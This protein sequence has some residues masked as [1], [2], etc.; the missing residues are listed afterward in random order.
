VAAV[1]R[2][3]LQLVTELVVLPDS[4]LLV[5]EAEILTARRL[6]ASE[7]VRAG[8]VP[9]GA[10][11]DQGMVNSTA[12]P[13]VPYSSHFGAFDGQGVLRATC[14]VIGNAAPVRLPTLALPTFDPTLRDR[15]ERY[16]RGA[17]AE[18]AA[19]ARDRRVGPEFPRSLFRSLWRYALERG[20]STYVLS[21]DALVLRTLRA[22]GHELFRVVGPETPAP[23]RPVFPV[24]V[25]VAEI[26]EEI[27][28]RGLGIRE[29]VLPGRAVGA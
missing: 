14:R 7:Y 10:I 9:E 13:W 16:P 11:T 27:F 20:V 22:M 24:W 3:D 4:R 12:D 26:R 29:I 17:M 8:Y 28:T 1:D 2:H 19:L 23:V 21:V 18:I 6:Q 5:D 25:D 15:F